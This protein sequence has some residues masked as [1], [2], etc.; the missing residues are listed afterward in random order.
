MLGIFRSLGSFARALGPIL[1]AL[2]FWGA[3]PAAPYFAAALLVAPTVVLAL[4]LPEP[5][6]PP[7]RG[8]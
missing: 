8:S 3:R 5:P 6:R 2:L 1:G 4:R 7:G